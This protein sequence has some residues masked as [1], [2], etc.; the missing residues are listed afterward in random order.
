MKQFCCAVAAEKLLILLPVP[1]Q[2][3]ASLFFD[4]IYCESAL[5][6]ERILRSD[7]RGRSIH[8]RI[9]LLLLIPTYS[10]CHE[11]GRDVKKKR[12]AY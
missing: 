1:A 5:E 6:H 4:P 2:Q 11:R 3:P 10:L 9:R 8:F 7:P 12:E